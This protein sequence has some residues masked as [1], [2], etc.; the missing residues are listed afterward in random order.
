MNTSDSTGIFWLPLPDS[1][2]NPAYPTPPGGTIP[3]LNLAVFPGAN[4]GV[5]IQAMPDPG[6]PMPVEFPLVGS[7]EMCGYDPSNRVPM[8]SNLAGVDGWPRSLPT[9]D[10]M[11]PGSIWTVNV[12][13]DYAKPDMSE[14]VLKTGDGISF[15]VGGY[16]PD[17]ACADLSSMPIGLTVHNASGSL[18]APDA[19]M[20]DAPLDLPD[21][22][23]TIRS[24]L[25]SD[26]CLPE[27]PTPQIMTGVQMSERPGDM[28]PRAISTMGR[29]PTAQAAGQVPYLQS[30]SD[31]TGM[32]TRRRRHMDLML[33]GL[34]DE[35]K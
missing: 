8:P 22:I 2:P 4:S 7:P 27:I 9:S 29:D 14:P 6:K 20:G 32:N 10:Q 24:P 12:T 23:Q 16:A 5:S 15:T 17:E 35:E 34:R 3:E 1:V 30:F 21:G 13:P 28:D 19:V 31:P 33:N 11:F 18:F 25:A 26:P